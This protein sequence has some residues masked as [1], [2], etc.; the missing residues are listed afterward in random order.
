MR[1][2]GDPAVDGIF[3]KLKSREGSQ[4]SWIVPGKIYEPTAAVADARGEALCNLNQVRH[5]SKDVQFVDHAFLFL[6]RR[7]V[8]CNIR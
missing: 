2:P 7:T 1:G 6:Y 8:A 3:A 4:I 5:E